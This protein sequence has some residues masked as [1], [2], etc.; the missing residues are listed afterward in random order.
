[1]IEYT[2]CLVYNTMNM[3]HCRYVLVQGK[4][5]IMYRIVAPEGNIPEGKPNE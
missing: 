5:S 2:G 3:C 1:M 4:L